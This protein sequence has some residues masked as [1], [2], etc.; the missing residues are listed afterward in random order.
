MKLAIL[1]GGTGGAKL[2][3]GLAHETAP[4]ELAIVCN[5]GDDIVLHGLHISPDLDTIAYTLAGSIDREKGWGVSGDTFSALEWLGK[6]GEETWFQ[7]G[8]RDP[9]R[10]IARTRILRDGAPRPAAPARG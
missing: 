1:T 7:L 9:P 8:E 6:Y 2:V 10:H 3:E 4:E 5:T